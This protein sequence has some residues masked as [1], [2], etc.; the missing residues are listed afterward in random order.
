MLSC[1]T[2]TRGSPGIRGSYFNLTVSSCKV[3]A[4]TDVRA[5]VHFIVIDDMDMLACVYTSYIKLSIFYI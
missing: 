4:G 3:C 1:K 2:R 5:H